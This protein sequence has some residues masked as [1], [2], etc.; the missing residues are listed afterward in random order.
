MIGED[1]Q[2]YRSNVSR[3]WKEIKEDL[4]RL[5]EYSDRVTQMKNKAA[6]EVEK[7]A[8]K[9]TKKPPKPPRIR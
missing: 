4:E 5:Y 2:N 8:V 7:P 3:I 6:D 1:R 9:N